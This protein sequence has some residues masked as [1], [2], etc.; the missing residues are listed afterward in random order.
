[1]PTL[2][3]CQRNPELGLR[4][5][6]W[7]KSLVQTYLKYVHHCL[8]LNASDMLSSLP[9]TTNTKREQSNLVNHKYY[10]ATMKNFENS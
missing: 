2:H 8:A 3:A 9:H 10:L 4:E 7:E 1:M 6:G 5:G